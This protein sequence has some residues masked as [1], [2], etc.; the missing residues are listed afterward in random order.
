MNNSSSFQQL[1]MQQE[2]IKHKRP[3]HLLTL[4]AKTGQELQE[5]RGKYIGYLESA[6][7]KKLADIC[8]TT[9]INCQHFKYRLAIVA[10]SVVEMREKLTALH[11]ESMGVLPNQDKKSKIAFLFAPQG[12]E[13]VG[14][15]RQL[16]QTQPTFRQAFD[17]CNDILRPYLE[18]P[19]LEILYPSEEMEKSTQHLLEETTYTHPA[20]FALEYALFELWKSWG[21]QPDIV[22]G[23][24]AG[25]YFAAYIAGVFSLENCLKIVTERSR[26]MQ[27][28]PR[29]GAVVAVKAPEQEIRTAI[30]PFAGS[31]W[32]NSFNNPKNVAISGKSEEVRAVSAKLEAQGFQTK[33][34]NASIAFHT[35]LM[36]SMLGEFERVFQ[37]VSF[38]PPQIKWVSSMTGK[39]VTDEVTTPDYWCNQII[40]P[41]ELFASVDS[42]KREGVEVFVEIGPRPIVWRLTSQGQLDNETLWLPSLSPTETDWQQML[43]STAK[44][45]LHGVPVDWVGFDRDYNRSPLPLPSYHNN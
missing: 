28:L 17:H 38:S 21:I 37:D 41:V 19:L 14:M 36:A 22:M 40:E 12:Y 26:L 23:Y 30:A 27:E 44:L 39:V 24:S 4:S 43:T 25:E 33:Q 3:L 8:F 7:D 32:I 1:N 29:V 15:G 11:S 42:L 10:S 31:V 18:K 13:Y 6:S 35:P 16:Y 5:L 9:N 2:K 45:Y 20:L 34:L